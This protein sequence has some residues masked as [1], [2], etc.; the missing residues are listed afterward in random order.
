MY[1]PHTVTLY[2]QHVSQN[3]MLEDVTE[4]NITVLRGVFYDAVKASNVKTGGLENADSVTLFIPFG[5]GAYDGFLG[6]EKKYVPPKE[7]EDAADKS[8]IWTLIPNQ[9]CF[10]IK[11]TAVAPAA[12]TLGDIKKMFDDVRIVTKVDEKDFGSEHMRHWQV[13]GA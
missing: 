13:G 11:G 6:T 12:G 3:D 1:A 9:K 2:N 5:V 4:N 8:G 10:F 7:Y